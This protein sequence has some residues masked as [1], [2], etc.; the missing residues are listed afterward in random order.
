MSIGKPAFTGPLSEAEGEHGHGTR[1][2]RLS[3]NIPHFFF[4]NLFAR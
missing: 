1:K 4:Q 2:G 3:Q